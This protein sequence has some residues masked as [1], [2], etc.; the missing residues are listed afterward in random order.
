MEEVERKISFKLLSVYTSLSP[1]SNDIPKSVSAI[2]MDSE[3]APFTPR[4]PEQW[5]CIRWICVCVCA[6]TRAHTHTHTHWGE[7]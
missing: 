5:P 4:H 3:T 2:S 7:V 6:H 1:K